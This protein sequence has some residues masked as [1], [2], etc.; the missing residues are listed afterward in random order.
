MTFNSDKLSYKGR[1]LRTLNGKL[2]FG[3]AGERLFVDYL[4]KVPGFVGR[5]DF[6][7]KMNLTEI[8]SVTVNANVDFSE[9][10]TIWYPD[11]LHMSYECDKL[12]FSEDKFITEDDI[13]VSCQCW[14]NKSD[15]DLYIR[16]A[17]N[18]KLC[19]VIKNPD[20]AFQ[21]L[22]PM[23][24][25]GYRAG[26]YLEAEKFSSEG[27]LVVKPGQ[28]VEFTIAAVFGNMETEKMDSMKIKLK[29]Y[30]NKDG[31]RLDNQI[32]NYSHFFDDIPVFKSSSELLNKVWLYR[33]Y[34]LKNTYAK[35]NYGNF[36]H[37]VM[38]EGRSH[39]MGKKPFVSEGWEFSKLI[40]LTTPLHIIDML[41]KSDDDLIL[42]MVYSLID[43]QD[44]N[45]LFRVMT[46]NEFGAPYANFAIWAIYQYYL[47]HG[48]KD[49][50]IKI[51]PNIKRYID[52]HIKLYSSE[53]DNLQ[54]ERIHQRTGKEYQ[55]SYWYFHN[56]PKD[57]LNPETY[58]FL[59]RVDRSIY[60][61]LNLVGAAELCKVAGDSKTS[62]YKKTADTLKEEINTKMWDK[63]SEFYYDLHYKTDEKSLV[64]NIVGFY[65]FWADITSD[66]KEN[67]LNTLFDE[68]EFATEFPFP[69]VSKQCPAYSP[70][71]G[72]MGNYIKGR[73]G[74]VWCGPAW[75]YTNGIIVDALG[76]QSK[77]YN[78]K[79]DKEFTK[80]LRAYAQEHFRNND[81]N[82]PY[83]VEHYNP[84]TGE[85]LSDEV[86]Y[87]H[88]YFIHLIM[89]HVLGIEI[90]NNR[91]I[92]DPIDIG[93][94][95][96]SCEQI[97]IR[98][99]RLDIAFD[100]KKGFTVTWDKK[101]LHNSEM[102]T[103]VEIF[104]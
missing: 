56:Y 40:P 3:P 91:L 51:I 80:Y 2:L 64:K 44:E 42:E 43:S 59:K 6:I 99:H 55:P 90:H 75:P 76:K 14:N 93:L 82:C 65:P 73:D 19:N 16:L 46:V 13:A 81:L 102:L 30:L 15:R 27:V 21:V 25:Y 47:K 37:G 10:D 103:K 11:R 83:L 98:G 86:D 53:N 79:Y 20:G 36:K 101:E 69:S 32:E 28:I 74:C 97:S 50:I 4:E 72:W 58:T 62:E 8:F 1:Y 87:N 60:H 70:S 78:H 24:E 49:F 54:I 39:K 66:D 85:L 94:D 33:W 88:S 84:E 96:F 41:W 5:I 45:G 26:Y 22:T 7:H 48:N 77:K 68:N 57:Y 52:G 61:Y 95:N 38:F 9:A 31:N 100:R 34:I 67:S 92:I 104:L 17:C 29:A 18:P 89:S 63:S 35:P 12:T 23:T 71:G